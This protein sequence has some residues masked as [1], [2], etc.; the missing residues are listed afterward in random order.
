MAGDVA[1]ETIVEIHNDARFV[2][3]RQRADVAE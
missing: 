3:I 1:P 2:S